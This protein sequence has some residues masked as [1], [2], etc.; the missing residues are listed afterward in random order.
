MAQINALSTSLRLVMSVTGTDG[1]PAEK[2]VS[3]SRIDNAITADKA[4]AVGDALAAL[5]EHPVTATKKYS[6]GILAE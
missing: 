4:K 5:L 2:T 1:K 6:V 3:L